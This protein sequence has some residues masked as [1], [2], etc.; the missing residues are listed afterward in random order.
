VCVGWEPEFE[1]RAIE[2][3]HNFSKTAERLWKEILD[4]YSSKT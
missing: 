3:E 4:V 2:I 1:K